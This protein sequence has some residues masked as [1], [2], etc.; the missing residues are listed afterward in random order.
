MPEKGAND[1]TVNQIIKD[2]DMDG[3][4]DVL[5][6]TDNEPSMIAIQQQVKNRRPHKTV[7]ENSVR[8]K[9]QTNGFIE[10][11]NQFVAGQI[12]TLRCDLQSKL[13]GKLNRNHPVMTWLVRYAGVLI[14]MFHIGK[15]GRTPY[16]R[17]KGKKAHPN[18][19]DFAEKVL[20]RPVKADKNK[21]EDTFIEGVFFGINARNGEY[22][23]GTPE[24]FHDSRTIR[25]LVPDRRWEMDYLNQIRG[26]PWN[27]EPDSDNPVRINICLLYTSPSPRD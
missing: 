25:R 22:V 16:E 5:F 8:G 6:K 18:L 2:I 21:L 13:T 26:V 9:S 15:D 10:N 3:H 7:C 19:V 17:R 14:N 12:R 11:A 27:L 20:F 1:Y 4:T 23:M 24:G